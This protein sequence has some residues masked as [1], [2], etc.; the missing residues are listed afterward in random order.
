MVGNSE[1]KG[2]I[3]VASRIVDYLSSGLYESPAACLKELVNNSF[4]ADATR[5]DLFIKPDADRIIIEDNGCG[6]NRA[7]FVK[8]FSKI[9]ESYKRDDSEYTTSGRPKIG[10]IGIGFIAANE[11][12]DVMEIVSTKAGDKE[13]L[14]VSINFDL[15]RRDPIERLRDGS[16]IAKA[17]YVGKIS[18]TEKDTHFTQIF[19]K[20]IRGEA[21]A[22]LAGARKS[23]FVSGMNSLYGLKPE[24]ILQRLKDK[25]LKTWSNFDA[26]SNNALE[27]GLNVPVRYHDEWIPARS[28]P[29]VSDI[30]QHVFSLDFK[31]FI[32]RSEV[33]KPI[34]FYPDG[35]S[36][37][38]KFAFQGKH[39]AADGYFY[40]QHGAIKPQELQG[41]L[42]RIRNAAVGDYDPNF[43][44]FS[45]SL[46][47]LFQSWISGEV[48]ADDRLEDAM[49]IDRR[50]LRIAHPAYEEL[51]GAI[52]KHLADLI[53]RVRLEIYG[54]GSETRK[55]EQA[56]NVQKRIISVASHEIERVAPKAAKK[57]RK[58]WKDATRDE[59][60]RERLLR[61]FTVDQFYKIVVEVAGEIM[62]PS[63][64]EQFINRLTERL[65]K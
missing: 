33:R 21:R 39:V 47:P 13:L 43:L 16:D 1:F 54:A 29:K 12:C 45:S 14:E 59:I 61:K 28:R 46:G 41:L 58:A 62:S 25:N 3:V 30:E 56:I 6:M 49:N 24:S 23:E 35:K 27:I 22:I 8:H 44:G 42:I 26:Y 31:V 5:V 60:G 2:E 36:L 11:I 52:H 32:D 64:L 15:M 53:K 34:V 20:K 19:L 40:A 51:Q 9:S 48:L 18:E 50:T 65:R 38:S 37:I 17:D 10:K 7:D 55:T 4:D 57:I 63:Q